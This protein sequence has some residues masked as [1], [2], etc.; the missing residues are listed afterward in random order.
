MSYIRCVFSFCLVLCSVN[1]ADL[2]SV[3]IV[4]LVCPWFME[5]LQ[6]RFAVV[7]PTVNFH[8]SSQEWLVTVAQSR[9][10]NSDWLM[11]VWWADS[12]EAWRR[13]ALRVAGWAL[14]QGRLV[15][16]ELLAGV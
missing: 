15:E 4:T 2:E 12:R 16:K 5:L 7:D 6:V 8:W 10:P 1:K 14:L 9:E 13:M 11:S 3:C